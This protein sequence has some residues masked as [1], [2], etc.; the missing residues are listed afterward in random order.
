MTDT[1]TETTHIPTRT[2]LSHSMGLALV[3][4]G[5]ATV[6]LGVWGFFA[7]ESF[8]EDFPI[9]GADWVSALGPFN[10]HL[11][12]DFGS[13]EIG[14]GIA[15]IGVGW[16]RSAEGAVSVLA[17]AI[18]FGVLHLTYHLDTFKEF[19][20]ASAASQAVAL[21]LFIAIPTVLIVMIG[22]PSKKEPTT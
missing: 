3:V 22:T 19:T 5:A 9:R 15:A 8:F 17:G 16:F 12:T 7:P 10:E 1:L 6:A 4:F 21:S 14:L 18:I 2:N 13:A 11:V 20:T